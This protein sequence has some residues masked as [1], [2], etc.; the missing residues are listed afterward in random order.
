MSN[1]EEDTNDLSVAGPGSPISI[2]KFI[3]QGDYSKDLCVLIDN[4][5]I[6]FANDDPDTT[7]M[8]TDD[9]QLQAKWF[10]EDCFDGKR[11]PA[12]LYRYLHMMYYDYNLKYNNDQELAKAFSGGEI[13]EESA[14][15]KHI[16]NLIKYSDSNVEAAQLIGFITL[17]AGSIKL[18]RKEKKPVRI[19]LKN[20]DNNL[21]PQMASKWMGLF[22]NI[23][24]EYG[25]D[26][27]G[28]NNNE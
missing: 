21:H 12:Y 11:V 7:Y 26:T 8:T 16:V 14:E 20:P 23:K 24:K 4:A 13:T 17:F 9:I 6:G 18:A 15:Y 1:Q 22:H 27:K 19:F 10:R 25:L 28:E 2:K 3:A 5:H